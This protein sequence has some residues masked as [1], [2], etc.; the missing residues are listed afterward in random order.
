MAKLSAV[1]IT[2][3]ESSRIERCIK[4]LQQIADEIIVLDSGSTD[5]TVSIANSLDAKVFVS[6][7]TGYA[8]QKNLAISFA[9]H[10]LIFSVDADEIPDD[11][12]I[13]AIRKLKMEDSHGAWA[14]NRLNHIGQSPIHFG[15]WFPD[16]KIRI[17]SKD[18]AVW[19]GNIVHEIAVCKSNIEIKSLPGF[20]LHFG[21]N[22]WNEL[23]AKQEYY[24]PL[25]IKARKEAGKR[26]GIL[27]ALTHGLARF[28]KDYFLKKGFTGGRLGLKMALL[29]TK[30]T[31]QRYR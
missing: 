11:T 13:H 8:N 29:A 16:R 12:L 1:I 14:V 2:L 3:N 23:V 24:L 26:G 10:N 18:A 17:W 15:A 25:E 5:E 19:E 28:G 6:P 4:A 21:Y 30:N 22:T 27:F 7:F 20:L 31:Y 9:S